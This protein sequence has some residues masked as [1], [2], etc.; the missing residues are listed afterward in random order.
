MFKL[1]KNNVIRHKANFWLFFLLCVQKVTQKYLISPQKHYWTLKE[2]LMFHETAENCIN[3]GYGL[4]GE[5]GV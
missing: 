1:F 5:H 2:W 3:L 4:S